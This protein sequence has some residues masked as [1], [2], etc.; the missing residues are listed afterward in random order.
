MPTAK[1]TSVSSTEP[2]ASKATPNIIRGA[3]DIAHP[4]KL[5]RVIE[6]S[7]YVTENNVCLKDE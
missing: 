1:T 6:L 5:R 4:M 2:Y 7:F 3:Y